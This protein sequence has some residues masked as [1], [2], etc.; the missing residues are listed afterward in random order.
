MKPIDF[1]GDSREALQGFPDGARYR[2]GVELRAV[3][4]G[5]DPADWKPMKTVGVG[6]RE[7]RI[8]EDSGAFRVI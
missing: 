4:T 8:K 3:Q 7:I 2:I 1:L 5:L 6:V